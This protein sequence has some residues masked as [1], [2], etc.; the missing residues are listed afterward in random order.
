MKK[1]PRAKVLAVLRTSD[2]RHHLKDARLALGLTGLGNFL[3]ISSFGFIYYF[4][5]YF[6]AAFLHLQGFCAPTQEVPG[7]PQHLSWQGAGAQSI[8]A[9]SWCRDL[10]KLRNCNPIQLLIS[11]RQSSALAFTAFYCL[12]LPT[13]SGIFHPYNF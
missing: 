5:F 7:Q 11:T 3:P 8:S 2:T 1:K 9:H 10:W 13:R 6:L 4:F 12:S